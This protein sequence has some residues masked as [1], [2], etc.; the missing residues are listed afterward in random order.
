MCKN[1]D[2][3]PF[4]EVKPLLRRLQILVC[5]IMITESSTFV[6]KYGVLLQ[7]EL[8]PLHTAVCFD[9]NIRIIN[10]KQ[11]VL[12]QLFHLIYIACLTL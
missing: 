10:M 9:T 2:L 7:V 11:A 5:L 12:I 3:L 1:F 8:I 4:I 6:G